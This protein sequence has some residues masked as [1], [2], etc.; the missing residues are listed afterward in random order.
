MRIRSSAALVA[1]VVGLR[2]ALAGCGYIGEVRA[3][4]A[5][6]DGNKFYAASDWSGGREIRGGAAR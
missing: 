2:V 6:K 4:K 5:F 1:L 3:M